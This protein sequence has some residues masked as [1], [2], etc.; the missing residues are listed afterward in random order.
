[1]FRQQVD[2][3]TGQFTTG[4]SSNYSPAALVMLDYTWRLADSIGWRVRIGHP[5]AQYSADAGCNSG[6]V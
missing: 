4:E 3:E 1:M 5:R 2:P 6:R